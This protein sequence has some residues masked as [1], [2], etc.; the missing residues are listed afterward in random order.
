[1]CSSFTCLEEEKNNID[2][3]TSHTHSNIS[4]TPLWQVTKSV[5]HLCT[6]NHFPT[7]KHWAANCCCWATSWGK[8][9]ERTSLSASSQREAQRRNKSCTR[10]LK[11]T[12]RPREGRKNR[13]KDGCRWRELLQE[14]VQSKKT[15][16]KTLNSA[17]S[18]QVMKLTQNRI[19]S[20]WGF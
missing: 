18:L 16:Q 13:M 6:S 2:F 4:I 20:F 9:R 1:M 19:C 14:K 17:I 15:K 10:A 12:F 7:E 5:W 3:P 11:E 8:H